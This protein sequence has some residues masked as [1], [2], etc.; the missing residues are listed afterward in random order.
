ML[1]C[2][3]TSIGD[4]SI[5]P[6]CPDVLSSSMYAQPAHCG[7]HL[8]V[9][10]EW[11]VGVG[12]RLEQ[13]SWGGYAALQA[14]LPAATAVALLDAAAALLKHEPTV[15]DVCCSA[16]L[17]FSTCSAR[18]AVFRRDCKL[19]KVHMHAGGAFGAWRSGDS[20]GRHARP[21]A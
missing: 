9:S 19:R 7:L 20:G 6:H 10:L 21:A 16:E 8:Q 15:I 11:A 13:A 3:F 18:Q 12:S 2:T 5:V 14:V 4:I 17:R 1:Y